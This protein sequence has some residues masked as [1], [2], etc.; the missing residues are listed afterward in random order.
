[1][2]TITEIIKSYMVKSDIA[3]YAK[4]TVNA[5]DYPGGTIKRTFQNN[6]LIGN[7]FSFIDNPDGVWWQ[8]DDGVYNPSNPSYLYVKNNPALLDIP[9]LPT[10]IQDIQD[11]KD[12]ERKDA[13]GTVPFYIEKYAPWI[14]GGIV[15]AIALPTLVNSLKSKKV[16]GKEDDQQKL[17]LLVGSGVLAY[18][19][20]QKKKTGSVEIGPLDT[21]TFGVKAPGSIP[22]GSTIA[23]QTDGTG[24][25]QIQ[26]IGIFPVVYNNGAS[27]NGVWKM[28]K[29]Y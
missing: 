11:K 10:L 1:M 20:F 5:Y 9:L 15:A 19:I 29:K 27:V 2:P 8:F 14:V 17:A 28:D 6:E 13:I 16:S 26:S 12:Q 3:V 18:F 21:G 7:V 24:T 25:G 22:S 23:K 4:G